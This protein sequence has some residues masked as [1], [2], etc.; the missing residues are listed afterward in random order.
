MSSMLED[1]ENLPN[2]ISELKAIKETL[3]QNDRNYAP[4]MADYYISDLEYYSENPDAWEEE[5]E[6]IMNYAYYDNYV[7]WFDQ[8]YSY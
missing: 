1:K 3:I 2:V 4:V 7:L 5:K 6:D 8:I